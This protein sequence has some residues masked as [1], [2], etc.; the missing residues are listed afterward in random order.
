MSKT[1]EPERIAPDAHPRVSYRL[2]EF[3]RA[4]GIPYSTVF[5][6]CKA[7]KIPSV[8]IGSTRVIPATYLAERLAA[9]PPRK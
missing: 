2:R 9:V 6:Q 5:D 7:G 1:R 8:L 4:T 3:S